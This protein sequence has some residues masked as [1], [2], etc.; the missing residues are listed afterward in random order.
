MIR[1]LFARH[2]QLMCFALIGVANTLVHGAI[3]VVA[4]EWVALGVTVAHLLAFCVANIFSYL[5]NSWLTF[6]AALSPGRYARFFLASLLSLG[7][8]LLLAWMSELYGLH[9]LLGFILIVVVVPLLSFAVMKFWTFA[10]VG[11][12]RSLR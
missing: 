7:L 9:Y 10:H 4:V 5:M 1:A 2:A 3:L 12:A 6:K 8:T 11:E